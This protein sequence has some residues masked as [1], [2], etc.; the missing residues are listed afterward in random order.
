MPGVVLYVHPLT[1]Q[2][3]Q[4]SFLQNVVLLTLRTL[5]F[6]RYITISAIK[7]YI[8]IYIYIYSHQNCR[9]VYTMHFRK[10]SSCVIFLPFT[11]FSVCKH[12]AAA[13][14]LAII[15][16]P[17]TFGANKANIHRRLVV[18]SISLPRS[19]KIY[20]TQLDIVCEKNAVFEPS[21]RFMFHV[22][23]PRMY[24][25]SIFAQ[26]M[27]IY[28]PSISICTFLWSILLRKIL[29]YFQSISVVCKHLLDFACI[30]FL[31]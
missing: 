7:T 30:Y 18:E 16:S 3:L 19:I 27:C 20:H 14:R 10:Y 17:A 21:T 4:C 29:I 9:S 13:V 25:F 24:L 8:Y 1:P 23:F 28:I 11:E 6:E 12:V 15:Q 26:R 2:F 31:I 22:L 5:I